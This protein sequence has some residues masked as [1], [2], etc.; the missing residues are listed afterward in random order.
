[1]NKFL[2]I[3]SIFC[4]LIPIALSGCEEKV[5]TEKFIGTWIYQG[6]STLH[7]DSFIFY[8]N[9]SVECIY[10]WPDKTDILHQWNQYTITKDRVQIGQ[11]IYQYSFSENY[12]RLYLN[13][14]VYEKQS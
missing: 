8:T 1:M 3:C 9:G 2:V 4:L 14:E 6:N 7:T 5:D 10:H 13:G 11:T 12:H